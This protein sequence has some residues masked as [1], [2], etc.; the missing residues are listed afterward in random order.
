MSGK[1]IVVEG[2]DAVGKET[3]SRLLFAEL[4]RRGYKVAVLSFPMYDSFFGTLVRESLDGKY[5]DFRH[6]HPKWASLPYML[7]RICASSTIE[8]HLAEN[9]FVICN[10]YVESNAAYG[11]AKL[12]GDREEFL[13]WLLQAEYEVLGFV[14]KPFRVILLDTVHAASGGL[15]S[16]RRRKVDQYEA[17]GG[18]Q[19]QVIWAYKELARHFPDYWHVVP[20]NDGAEM[21]GM[22][23]ISADVLRALE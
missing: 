22:E 20:C 12:A 9:D 15:L 21:R 1:L 8:M 3:Q 6:L 18:Y 16:T 11:M 5:G 2:G 13:R 10:R 17:D 4:M 23:E 7:D 14:P 19:K